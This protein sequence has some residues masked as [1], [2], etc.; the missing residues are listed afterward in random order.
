MIKRKSKILEEINTV[1]RKIKI[2]KK[3]QVKKKINNFFKWVEGT[4]LIELKSCNVKEL[5]LIHI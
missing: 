1:K 2:F 3:R 5:S 4:Q